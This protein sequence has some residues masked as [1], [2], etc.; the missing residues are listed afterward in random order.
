[1]TGVTL[2]A[3]IN[4]FMVTRSAVFGVETNGRPCWR[5][6]IDDT[7]AFRIQPRPEWP[8]LGMCIPW[9]VSAPLHADNEWFATLSRIRS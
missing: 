1:M 3:S 4:S 6:N 7:N 9:G 5:T 2:P 8:L